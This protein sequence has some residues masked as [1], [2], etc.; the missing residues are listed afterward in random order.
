MQLP[1][2]AVIFLGMVL[3]TGRQV[4]TTP[5]Y[6]AV[7][8]AEVDSDFSAFFSVVSEALISTSSIFLVFFSKNFFP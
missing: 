2:S 5:F 1:F 8:V 3:S 7:T 6:H 4:E